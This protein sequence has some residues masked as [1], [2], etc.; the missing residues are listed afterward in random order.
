VRLALAVD[1]G[2][3]KTDVALVREDGAVLGAIRGPSSSPQSLGVEAALDVIGEL[4]AELAP[5][6]PPA[7]ALLLLAGVDFPDE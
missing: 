1:G 6:E 4:I 2:N 5:A 3:S 7:A